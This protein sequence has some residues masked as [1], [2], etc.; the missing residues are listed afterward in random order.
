M[1]DTSITD[2]SSRIHIPAGWEEP[3]AFYLL[4]LQAGR[5]YIFDQVGVDS[6]PLHEFGSSRWPNVCG[7]LV[8][9]D[10]SIWFWNNAEDVV[11]CDFRDFVTDTLLEGIAAQ[12]DDQPADEMDKQLLA[13]WDSERADRITSAETCGE[14]YAA[15]TESIEE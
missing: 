2:T 13:L 15:A 14:L 10:N 3:E 5:A 1:N 8:Y 7:Y 11:H 9:D 12:P 6:E 4:Q